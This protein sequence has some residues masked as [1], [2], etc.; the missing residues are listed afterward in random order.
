MKVEK[1]LKDING[2]LKKHEN[3][4]NNNPELFF[5]I[6]D[7][8]L[9]A[10]DD[11]DQPEGDENYRDPED[12]YNQD[13]DQTGSDF[14]DDPEADDAQSE[15]ED[16][17]YTSADDDGTSWINSNAFDSIIL[18][19]CDYGICLDRRTGGEYPELAGNLFSNITNQGG[20]CQK[21]ALKVDGN[22]NYFTN[23]ITWDKSSGFGDGDSSIL[24]TDDTNRCFFQGW[25]ERT[26]EDYF[27]DSGSN[28]LYI[29]TQKGEIRAVS[30]SCSTF[31]GPT[32]GGGGISNI[33][34]DTTP[35]LGGDLDGNTHG[36]KSLTYLS[37]QAIS[38]QW[39][40]PIYRTSK[41][42]ASVSYEGRMILSSGG[43]D[44][45]TWIWVCV[46]NDA[47]SYEWVQI[48]VSS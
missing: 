12:Y 11:E 15:D 23:F 26:T 4:L 8:L 33:V 17:Q 31:K 46:H 13:E 34:E 16:A 21:R 25:G 20:K 35:Q 39:R 43:A 37:S 19:R 27:C 29:D 42:A 6:E 1:L 47:N 14:L 40:M 7:R 30:I 10:I 48:G 3:F 32:V 45:K 38:G 24:F 44:K 5:V 36:I 2:L 41:P 18:Q 28:N 22:Y 9:K